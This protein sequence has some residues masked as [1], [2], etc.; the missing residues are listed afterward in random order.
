[1]TEYYIICVYFV[2]VYL[3]FMYLF[4]Y[5]CFYADWFIIN[6]IV[7]VLFGTNSCIGPLESLILTG[8]SV[9][10]YLLFSEFLIFS[11]RSSKNDS[12]G[13]SFLLTSSTKYWESWLSTSVNYNWKTTIL[14]RHL[15]HK[16]YYNCTQWISITWY[17]SYVKLYI[18]FNLW[19]CHIYIIQWLI[20]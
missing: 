7:S 15:N 3:S 6:I 16:Y 20:L 8:L 19:D 10:C 11:S 5:F 2:C 4:L 13:L 12:V 18:E 17:T 1:M 14:L 9:A